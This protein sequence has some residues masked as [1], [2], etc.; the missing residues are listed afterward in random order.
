[1]HTYSSE[2]MKLMLLFSVFL[3]IVLFSGNFHV[4][5]FHKTGWD[6][7]FN[8]EPILFSRV[9]EYKMMSIS[10]KSTVGGLVWSIGDNGTFSTTFCL[11]DTEGWCGIRLISWAMGTESIWSN[12]WTWCRSK[13]NCWDWSDESKEFHF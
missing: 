12:I 7:V 9:I 4:K 6:L 13:S 5:W 10:W 2:S 8:M 11:I 3:S 1:M